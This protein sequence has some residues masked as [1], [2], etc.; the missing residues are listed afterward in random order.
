MPRR[1]WFGLVGTGGFAREVMPLVV[2]QLQ[3]LAPIVRCVFV[4][5]E[6]R[7][8][9]LDGYP[10]MDRRSFLDLKGKK[11]FNV[12]I[13]DSRLR[14]QLAEDLIESDCEPLSILAPTVRIVGRAVDI[15]V[16]AILCD[17]TVITNHVQIGSFFHANLFSYVAHDCEIGN[18]VTFAPRVSCNGCVRIGDHAYLGT[19]AAIRNG[20]LASKV[21]IGERAVIG[22]H[23][24][25]LKNVP[26]GTTV[27]G[28][29]ARP[30]CMEAD[31]ACG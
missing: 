10:V 11:F 27:V 24:N 20:Q 28:N 2:E 14:Q 17:Y 29:P 12:A 30:T 21:L 13:A 22:M 7:E 16:G 8:S 26:P 18:F 19:G 25:V 6:S 23:S 4:G 1:Q 31:D 9:C 15:G 3:S 5:E